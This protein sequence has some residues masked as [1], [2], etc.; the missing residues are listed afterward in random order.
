MRNEIDPRLPVIV[1]I[2]PDLTDQEMV[3]IAGALTR[4]NV[5]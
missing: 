1:K 3:D 4:R 5:N 2:A